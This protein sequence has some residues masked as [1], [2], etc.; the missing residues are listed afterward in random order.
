M[1]CSTQRNAVLFAC[2]KPCARKKAALVP[3]PFCRCRFL[4]ITFIVTFNLSLLAQTAPVEG[5]RDNTPKV[6][7]LINARIVTA[8]GSVIARGTVVVRDGLIE[9]AGA[10]ILPP[11]DAR[12]WDY[13]GRTIYSGLIE[14]YSHL[15]FATEAKPSAGEAAQPVKRTGIQPW[16]DR[17]RAHENAKDLFMPDAKAAK[18]LRELGFGAALIVPPQG[19]FRGASTLIS[20]GEEAPRL[21]SLLPY[22]A[23]HLAFETS[24]F[25]ERKYPTSLLGAIALIR[26]TLL[27]AQWYQEAQAAYRKNPNQTRPEENP[28]LA[29]LAE[30]LRSRLLIVFEASGSNNFLRAVNIAREFP[31]NLMVRGSGDEYQYLEQIKRANVP[32]ILPLDF[33]EAPK[34]D[35]P[36]DALEVSLKDLQHWSMAPSNPHWLHQARITFALTASKL[37]KISDFPQRVRKA[38][39][40][41][42]PAEAALAALTTV[43]A[44]LFGVENRLGTIAAGK[45]ANLVIADGDLF[46]EKTAILDVWVEGTRYEVKKPNVA[47]VRG[48]WNFRLQK[49]SGQIESLVLEV[50]GSPE[51]PSGE[52]LKNDAKAKLDKFQLEEK[53]IALLFKGDTLGYGGVVSMSGVINKD[54]MKGSGL[55]PDGTSLGWSAQRVAPFEEKENGK[56]QAPV[57]KAELKKVFPYGG[58]GRPAPPAQPE[59]LLV[60]GATIWT[61]GALGKI[62]DADLLVRAGTI[63]QVGRDLKAPANA[64]VIEAQGQHITPGLIDAHSH[65]ATDAINEAGQAVTAEVRIGDVLDCQDSDIYRQLAGGLTVAHVM[66]GSAN[67]IGGQ[68]QTIKLRWGADHEGIKFLETPPTIKFALGENVKQSNW[69]PPTS[70]YPQTRMG[71]EQL[72]RDRF[73]AAGDYEREWNAYH[74]KKKEGLTIPPRRDLELDALVEILH[75]KRFIHCH[76]YRQ[77]EILMLMRLAEAIGFKVG[78]FQHVLEGYKVAEAIQQHGAGASS[79]S[80]WWAY[81]FEVYDAIPFNG[82]LLHEQGVVV[83]YNSDSGELARRLNWEAAKAVKYGNVPAEEALKFVTLNPAKQ[84]KIDRYVGSL[85]PG[86]HADFVIWSGPPLSAY[87]ICEQTWIEGRKYFD[88]EEDLKLRVEVEKERMDLIQQVLLTKEEPTGKSAEGMSTTDAVGFGLHSGKLP[89]LNPQDRCEQPW[90]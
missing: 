11:P 63:V 45:I 50:K 86:K 42:L 85:E 36:E 20:L 69:N 54:E 75:G 31:L 19:I 55:L 8:P 71:V 52:F 43:P 90:R 74:A 70:R 66:H 53:R 49:S 88:R 4:L 79:F 78:T 59:A 82:A 39:E 89:A 46:A 60:R 40:H 44:R 2:K 41:G 26:Q 5:L 6:H 30:M 38:I 64:I 32:V 29:A 33:P 58:F 21:G 51:K 57:A 1:T 22:A 35:T 77:D 48:K 16:N 81:K 68:N 65:S 83:S 13:T 72:I 67:P 9:A 25:S 87:S 84:L 7:A 12:I 17:L 61:C 47:D 37:K 14:S 10:G 76:S 15:G 56:K 73:K 3:F 18:E 62:D 24:P 80:D 27:D 23:Q 28:A 34:V